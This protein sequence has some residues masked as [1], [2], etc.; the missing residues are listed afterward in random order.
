MIRYFVTG[1]D[2]GVGKT[3]V[4]AALL[5]AA[6]ARGLRAS[7]MK[8]AESG[9]GTDDRG[10]LVPLDA[11]ALWRA[12]GAI[13][14]LEEV[15]PYRFAAPVAPAVAA[16]RAGQPIELSRITAA[17]ARLTADDP[18]LFIAEGAGGLMVPYGPGIQASDLARALELPLLVVARDSLG[19]INHTLLTIDAARQRGL[20]V[21][22]VILNNV[23][24][25][26]PE[27]R[28][29]QDNAATIARESG[30]AVLGQVPH[31][32]QLAAREA[33]AAVAAS[34]DLAALGFPL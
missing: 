32:G 20:T 19:T 5:G 8:P 34:L 25:T 28:A 26:S 29:D 18:D 9:C 23:G 33:D 2:T 11:L 31:L 12:A 16:A 21:A 3:T 30:V 4:A 15:C 27:D 10:A 17:A 22:G 1:T 13:A 24:H 14:A 7:C 6:V